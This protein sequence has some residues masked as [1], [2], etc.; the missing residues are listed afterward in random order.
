MNEDT[1]ALFVD[2]LN[3]SRYS[4]APLIKDGLYAMRETLNPLELILD[5][6]TNYSQ[7]YEYVYDNLQ[8]EDLFDRLNP[9]KG[10]FVGPYGARGG[11]FTSCFWT[12]LL[13]VLLDQNPSNPEIWKNFGKYMNG[14]L[15]DLRA[16]MTSM[17][18]NRKERDTFPVTRL[19]SNIDCFDTWIIQDLYSRIVACQGF[20]DYIISVLDSSDSFYNMLSR[21]YNMT[22]MPY[23]SWVRLVK[24]MTL[25]EETMDKEQI[26]M[27]YNMVEVKRTILLCDNQEEL[28]SYMKRNIYHMINEIE[29][30]EDMEHIEQI[31]ESVLVKFISVADMELAKVFDAKLDPSKIDLPLGQLPMAVLLLTNKTRQGGEPVSYY[32]DFY[33]AHSIFMGQGDY[34]FNGA[35]DFREGLQKQLLPSCVA[36]YLE[37]VKT[38]NL[39]TCV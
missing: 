12:Y 32:D 4:N 38:H 28:F 5:E 36:G 20:M 15:Y 24:A 11:D 21:L 31:F 26:D 37:A 6:D 2:S 3:P 39:K 16:P 23:D 9:N 30:G 35:R 22:T 7:L 17:L 25:M 33:N 14:Y 29:E 8:D 34:E 10:G 13:S 1:F 18:R 27:P 19:M